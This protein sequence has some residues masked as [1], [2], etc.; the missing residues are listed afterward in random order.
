MKRDFA[1]PT[2]LALALALTSANAPAS[3]VQ[4]EFVKPDKFTDAGRAFDVAERERN[5]EGLKRHLVAQG[6]RRLAPGETLS[7]AV[8]DV[9]LAG[10]YEAR[11]RYTNEVRIVRDAYPPRIELD[12]RVARA[13]GSVVK[14]GHRSLR[15]SSFMMGSNRY[16]GDA[17]RY[18]KVLL[19]DWLERELT[20]SP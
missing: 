16:A 15:D 17:L 3:P 11:Q 1:F 12:F 18:E 13:D 9:D 6:A 19:D 20:R 4:V 10:S 8:T 7:V 5:L 14:E 2:V